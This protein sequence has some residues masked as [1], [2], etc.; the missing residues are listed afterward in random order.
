MFHPDVVGLNIED[1]MACLPFSFYINFSVPIILQPCFRGFIFV[2]RLLLPT[3]EEVYILGNLNPFWLLKVRQCIFSQSTDSV[4]VIAAS[5]IFGFDHK[6][7]S[8]VGMDCS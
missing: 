5:S 2:T 3:Y 1:I 6:L 7:G 4:V 8:I